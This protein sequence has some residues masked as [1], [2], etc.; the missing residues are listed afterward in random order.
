MPQG[1]SGGD[2]WPYPAGGYV[3]HH[4][5]MPV[6]IALGSVLFDGGVLLGVIGLAVAGG[7]LSARVILAASRIRAAA[8]RSTGGGRAPLRQPGS[9]ETARPLDP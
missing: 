3:Q 6:E 5:P 4:A 1:G 8:K 9:S 7:I 2:L